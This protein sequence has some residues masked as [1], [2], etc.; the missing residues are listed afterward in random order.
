MDIASFLPF[1]SHEPAALVPEHS[2]EAGWSAPL[3]PPEWH[4]GGQQPDA[5]TAASDGEGAT[6]AQT[7]GAP[8][9]EAPGQSSHHS[10]SV[11]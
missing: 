8:E 1:C 4:I 10:V 5:S 3:Q 7:P 6:A 9:A 11:T 2:S